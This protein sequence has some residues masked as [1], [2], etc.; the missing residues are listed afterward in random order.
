MCPRALASQ[1]IHVCFDNGYLDL[2]LNID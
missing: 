1:N 2:F